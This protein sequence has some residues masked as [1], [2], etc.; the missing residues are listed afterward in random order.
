[1]KYKLYPGSLNDLQ[2]V[3]ET[4][5]RNRGYT[6]P[7][8]GFDN[9]VAHFSEL[10]NL[11]EEAVKHFV[12][13]IEK[14]SRVD[15]VVDCDFDGY[16]SASIIYRYIKEN[17]PKKKIAYHLHD[18]KMHGLSDDIPWQQFNDSLVIIPDASSNDVK[19]CQVLFE[20]DCTVIILD[21]HII[22]VN[23]PYAV[24]VN[25]QDSSYSNHYL[26]G[27][28]VV[29]QFIRAL[30]EYYWTE[31]ADGYV[32]L[33]AVATV[34]DVMDVTTPENRMLID[35]G[36]ANITH[37][38][39]E[40]LAF[41]GNKNIQG[42]TGIDVQ[43]GIVPFVNAMVRVGGS[44][45]KDLMFKAF[46][47][48][49]DVFDYKKRGSDEVIEETIYERVARLCYNAKNR[50][51]R[52]S[53]DD[54]DALVEQIESKGM[55]QYKIIVVNGTHTEQVF[56]GIHAARLSD[57]YKKPC[58]VLRKKPGKDENGS[59][60]F[61]GSGRNSN[62]CAVENLK[63]LLESTGMFKMISGHDNAFGVEIV[64]ENIPEMIRKVDNMI[65]DAEDQCILADFIIGEFDLGFDVV[66]AFAKQVTPFCGTGFDEPIVVV[67]DIE[68]RRDQ[69]TIM[70]YGTSWKVITDEDVEIVKFGVGESDMIINWY[71]N[72]EDETI[73]MTAAGTL[74]MNQWAGMIKGQMVVKEYEAWRNS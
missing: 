11:A 56:T 36:L 48:E 69:V 1:M 50:Q 70:G 6:Y 14:H 58:L 2:N 41:K 65:P 35:K 17:F 62:Y 53:K 21:H 40:A 45:E 28:G 74:G 49:F 67:E 23:N 57:K 27:T 30:D 34:A 51:K 26:C 59:D 16:A 46:C 32:D 19:Q 44:D 39:L 22:E 10:E 66:A 60:V 47:C 12:L 54:I 24:V 4:V 55:D 52:H 3:R 64:K 71:N 7:T 18:G 63:A 13:G 20:N 31:S 42:I 37:P 9:N 33:V 5:F 61:G 68:V 38:L 8:G 43:F 73:C 72:T 29:W 15:L 25:S